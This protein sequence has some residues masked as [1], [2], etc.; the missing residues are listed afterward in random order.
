[1]GVIRDFKYVG[2][3]G[4]G[5]DHPDFGAFCC[6]MTPGLV[7]PDLGPQSKPVF[8]GI[9]DQ[10][11][12]DINDP[13]VCPAAPGGMMSGQM[14]TTQASFDQWYRYTPD[15]NLPFLIYLQ[16]AKNGNVF[17]FEADG[18]NEYFPLDGAGWGNN[19]TVNGVPHNFGFTTEL[20]L[21]FTYKGGETFSFTGDDDVWVFIAGKLAVDLGGVHPAVTGSVRLDTLGLTVGS[22][23][24]LD[25]FN[26]ERHTTNSDFRVD[27]DLTFSNCGTVPTGSAQ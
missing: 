8:A 11:N 2:D 21:Q 19:H 26:A 22:E 16:F 1:V 24:P 10:G 5:Q 20:H 18:A 9:C 4:P 17:T 3:P 14:L 6:T 23:Y 15:V 27:T 25:V 7:K 12:P 13:T